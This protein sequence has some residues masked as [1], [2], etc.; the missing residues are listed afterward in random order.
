NIEK[1]AIEAT[2]ASGTVEVIA[3]KSGHSIEI[4]IIDEGPGISEEALDKIS[5]PFFTT[6]QGGTGLGLMITKQIIEKHDGYLKIIQNEY[7]GST[8]RIILP[9]YQES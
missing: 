1:N 5:E 6:K 9:E 2:D 8:F 7:K 3:R 4:D